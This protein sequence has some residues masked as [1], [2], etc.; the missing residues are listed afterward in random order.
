M[1]R[2][3][4]REATD[5]E[6]VRQSIGHVVHDIMSL[7]ELQGRLFQS[8]TR[9]IMERLAPPAA[10]FAAGI[11]L[12]AAA[13]LLCLLAIVQCLIAAGV[14][15]GAAYGLVAIASLAVAAGLAA[16]AWQRFRK[17]PRAFARSQEELASNLSWIKDALNDLGDKSEHS[18]SDGQD[19][20]SS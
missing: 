15:A 12:F 1:I 10:F 8:D 20:P 7:V 19:W 14:P 9:E 13:V 6:T 11:L 16:W 4:S 17:L 2:L 3:K 18:R 5:S